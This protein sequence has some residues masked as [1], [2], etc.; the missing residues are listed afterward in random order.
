MLLVKLI[1]FQNYINLF[2]KIAVISKYG[3]LPGT[4]TLTRL[5]YISKY[6]SIYGHEL[7]YI[8]SDSNHLSNG[9]CSQKIERTSSEQLINVKLINS[10]KYSKQNSIF[11]LFSWVQFEIKLFLYL[12]FKKQDLILVSSPSIFS[13]FTGVLL[14]TLHK[15]KL[16]VDIRDI[17]PNTLIEEGGVSEKH[18]LIRIMHCL[19]NLG[20]RKADLVLSSIPNLRLHIKEEINRDT[21]F[22]CLPMGYDVED[23]LSQLEHLIEDIDVN[24]P[25]DKIIIGYVGSIGPTNNLNTFIEYI[26]HSSAKRFHFLI[27]GDGSCFASYKNT[28]K[29]NENVTF[30]GRVPKSMARA[31]IQICDVMYFSTH[32]SSIWKYGQSLNKLLDYML[33]GKTVVAAY[34]EF[35]FKSMINEAECGFYIK[36]NC[37]DSHIKIF[38]KLA[39]K[40][41]SYL[42]D[43]GES[44]KEWVISHR[45]YRFLVEELNEVLKSV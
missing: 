5:F 4:G 21:K 39:S 25:Q 7:E 31:Y 20:Y 35:G 15:C 22:H 44:G 1:K 34:P 19:Q 23:D 28:L 18:P 12:L 6:L 42:E 29:F 40:E 37:I 36:S 3:S 43:M 24:L 8:I 14:K 2:M 26:Q 17:W 41:K 9:L 30:T 33:L 13:I 27:V 38:D 32:V 16:V 45:D 10:I 11:R